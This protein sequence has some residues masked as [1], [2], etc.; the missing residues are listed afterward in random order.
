[1]RWRAGVEVLPEWPERAKGKTPRTPAMLKDKVQIVFKMRLI[2]SPVQAGL[3]GPS[4]AGNHAAEARGLP[5]TTIQVATFRADLS[6]GH[7]EPI[8]PEPRPESPEAWA[9]SQRLMKSPPRSGGQK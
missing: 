9:P 4:W 6:P 1:M 5:P 8:G 7:N 2:R 3:C